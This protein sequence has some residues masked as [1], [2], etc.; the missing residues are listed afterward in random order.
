M[1][2]FIGI[3]KLWY[4][5]VFEEAVDQVALKSWLSTATEV[6][7]S[8]QDT[9]AYSQ[10][11]P[12]ITDYKNELTGMCYHH[13]KTSA[14]ERQITFTMGEYDYSDR[15]ALEGGT[16]IDDGNGYAAPTGIGDVITKGIVAKLKTGNYIVFTHA[17][18]SVKTD[19]Q[20]KALGMGV[21]AKAEEDPSVD[22]MACEYLISGWD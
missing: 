1:V 22:G 18:I 4:G 19:T 15:A 16:V 21:T 12:D 2:K 7:N 13:D 6:K 11:D 8:H 20:E 9:F 10:D 14:G 5:D 17:F 3:Q